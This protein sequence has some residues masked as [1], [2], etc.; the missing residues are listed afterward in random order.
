MRARNVSDDA[1]GDH[2]IVVGQVAHGGMG[3][4]GASNDGAQ[5]LLY[6][7]RTYD[8]FTKDGGGP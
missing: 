1:G 6:Y 2:T 8:T 3:E 7:D 5:P 4:I